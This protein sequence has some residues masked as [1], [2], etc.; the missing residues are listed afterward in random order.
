LYA[1]DRGAMGSLPSLT[2]SLTVAIAF[3]IATFALAARTARSAAA[4]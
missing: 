1:G 4:Y 2:F 3:A